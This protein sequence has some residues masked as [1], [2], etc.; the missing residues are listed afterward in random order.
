MCHLG[1]FAGQNEIP[2]VAGPALRVHRQAAAPTSRRGR[3]TNDAGNMTSV[4]STLSTQRHREPRALPRRAVTMTP[5]HQPADIGAAANGRY[6]TT[7]IVLHWLIGIALLG[8]ITF[9]FLLDD[10]APRGTPDARRGRSTCT[11]RSA[12]CCWL[13]I[14]CAAAVA[15]ARTAPPPWPAT[16]PPWQQRAAAIGHRALYVCMVVMP[17]S[18]CDRVELQQ[19]RHPLLRPPLAAARARPAGRLRILQHPARRHRVGIFTALIAGHVA[20]ALKHALDRPRRRLRAASGRAPA[21]TARNSMNKTRIDR[22][23]A[24]GARAGVDARRSLAAVAAPFAY[25]PNEGSGTLSVIDTA[26]DKVVAEIAAGS[27]P[28]GTV[29]GRRRPHAPTSATSRTTGWCWSTSPARKAQR[30]DRARRIA[31]RRRHLARRPLGRRGGR[32]EPTRSPSSTRAPTRKVFVVKVRGKNPE[33]ASSART[34]GTSSSAP[35]KA[36]RST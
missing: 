15:A 6:S 4:A 32:G 31:R 19:A 10:L 34:A 29:I 24:L 14:A 1:G 2:R 28:R 12:S 27:K 35:R 21:A 26:N 16:M 22:F 33:H 7:A 3:R 8:Q 36:G 9:G 17:L 23:A 11:S 18:G 20:I 13:L 30:R 25:V 5:A